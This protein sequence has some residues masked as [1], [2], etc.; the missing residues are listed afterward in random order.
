MG[1]QRVN[2]DLVTEQQQ[3]Q[4]TAMIS[5]VIILVFNCLVFLTVSLRAVSQVPWEP[6]LVS[7]SMNLH[8]LDP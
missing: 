4:Y 7:I 1:L 5:K 2:H 8:D 6:V 3:Q